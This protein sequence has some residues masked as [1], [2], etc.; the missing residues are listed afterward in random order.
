MSITE[1]ELSSL[2]TSFPEVTETQ[3][4]TVIKNWRRINE[5]TLSGSLIPNLWEAVG[6][7]EDGIFMVQDVVQKYGVPFPLYTREVLLGNDKN[8]WPGFCIEFSPRIHESAFFYVKFYI[9]PNRSVDNN[10][11]EDT[12]NEKVSEPF[13]V[14]YW[15]PSDYSP[16]VDTIN[17]LDEILSVQSGRQFS[18]FEDE[19]YFGSPLVFPQN[20]DFAD[21]WQK[22]EA[23]VVAFLAQ[24]QKLA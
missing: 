24:V 14:P 22:E 2:R 11:K 9:T 7:H 18:L 20:A 23:K 10:S 16:F 1:S 17:T 6:D 12:E 13:V 4:E 8:I 15:W 3:A 19:K 5:L 21:L